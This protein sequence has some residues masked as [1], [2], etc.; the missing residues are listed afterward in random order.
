EGETVS[1]VLAGVL[2]AE[3]DFSRLPPNTPPAVRGMLRRC[4][5]RD[6]RHRL[7]DIGDA[8]IALEDLASSGSGTAA[9]AEA[10]AAVRGPRPTWPW[11]AGV[12]GA[13]LVGALAGRFAPAPGRAATRPVRFEIAVPRVSTAA[14][15]PDGRRVA[16]SS[17]GRLLV[18][19]LDRLEPREIPGADDAIRPFWSPDSGTIAYGAKGKLWKVS[20]EGGTPSVICQIAGALWDEDAGGAWLPDGRIVFSDGNTAIFQVSSQ[21]GDPVPI[22]K[23]DPKD[24]LHFHAVSALPG[25]KGFVFVVHRSGEGR[26]NNTIAVW[27]GG[28]PRYVLELAGQAVED[29]VYS[30]TGHLVFER[31]PVNAGVWAMPFSL[32]ELKATGEP[33][34]V[35]TGMRDPS[36]AADGTLVVLPPRRELPVN[37]VW[38][39]RDGKAVSRL[40]EPAQRERTAVI[41]PDGKRVAVSELT[42]EKTDIWEY[43]VDRGTRSRLTNDG[44]ASAPSWSP[45]GRSVLYGSFDAVRRSDSVLKRVVAD[46]SGRAEQIGPGRAGVEFADGHLL[47]VSVDQQGWHL[48]S[49]SL[50]DANEKPAALL[51]QAYYSIQAVPSPDGRFIAYEAWTDASEAEIYLRRFPPSEGV[52]QVSTNGGRSPRWSADGHLYFSKG[53]AIYEAAVTANPDVRVGAPVLV[54]QRTAASGRSVPHDFNVAP[55]GKHFL[56]YEIAGDASDD[57]MTVTLNWFAELRAGSAGAKP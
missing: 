28:K 56:V 57:R 23:P 45:D 54:F 25:G 12:V 26:G 34:L 32:A 42:G 5:D 3:V 10:A 16:I 38:T 40:G 13:L 43:D 47:Y 46:G 7:R 6:V 9:P 37:L 20:A 44:D 4:L 55:D 17:R 24:E 52:W 49:R 1:D 18:R 33:F 2:R 41:S 50:K 51:P 53:P 36:V 22:L 35:S 30:P 29:A 11:A 39:D 14:I 15:S 48:W 19:D 27:S 31:S 21:G 8:R